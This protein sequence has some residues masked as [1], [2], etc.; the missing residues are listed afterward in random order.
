MRIMNRVWERFRKKPVRNT[1]WLLLFLKS[2]IFAIVAGDLIYYTFYNRNNLPDIEALI[3]FDVP[4]IGTIYDQN[5]KTVIHLAKE[6]RWTIKPEEIPLNVK[7]AVFSAEDKNFYSHNGVDWIA[8]IFRAGGKN[9]WHSGDTTLKNKRLTIVYQQGA[10][11][12]T[13]QLIG[14]YFPEHISELQKSWQAGII[15]RF[16]PRQLAKKTEELRLAMWTEEELAKS[17]YFGSKQ[18]VKDEILARFLSFTYFKKVYGIKAAARLYCGKEIG[19]LSYGETALL[20]GIIKQPFLYAPSNQPTKLAIQRQINR[21]NAVIDLMIENGY[22]SGGLADRLKEADIPALSDN[23]GN[24]EAPSIVGDV[25]G[26]VKKYGFDTDKIF[27][28]NLFVHTVINLDIQKIANE[29][30][31]NGLKSYEDRHPEAKG[32]IQGSVV[33]LRNSD[34]A[35][36]AEVGGRQIFNSRK[37]AYTDFN[38]VKHSLRQPGSAFKPFVYLEAIKNGWTLESVI[39]DG[40][41]AVPMGWTK[42]NDKWVKKP[43]KWISNY[44]GKFKG[45]IPLRQA[46]AESRNAATIRLA[47]IMG[48]DNVI[49]T[50]RLAGVRTKLEPYITTALG[51]S[52]VNLLELANAYRALASGVYAEPYTLAKLTDRNGEIIFVK[53]SAVRLLD[54]DQMALEQIQE[55]LRGVI[56]IPGG[57]AHSLDNEDFPIPI[58]GKTGTTNDFRDA[59]FI[60]STYGPG[61]I[62][63][64][65]RVGYDDNH[66]LGD[67]ETGA[68]VVLPIFK[69]I[70]LNVYSH[71]L[72]GPV[73]FFPESIEKNIDD[74]LHPPVVAPISSTPIR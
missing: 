52:E 39:R 20:A 25:F 18:R 15:S 14:L 38:R 46:L 48:I 70:M 65:I 49:Q 55:G 61:G 8:L 67:K 35:I 12:I 73:P 22:V 1:I 24:T 11:T 66:E 42:I 47:R 23:R 57:T 45:F 10:S 26:E 74:F 19:E 63:V 69:E 60:G 36:L 5:G 54:I 71:G 31:E 59:L 34:G 64:A 16:V 72:A 4:Q 50:A 68:R 2:V 41:I 3:R 62:T 33:V 58:M 37:I 7:Q 17:K 53:N 43:S 21:R 29:A 51:A 27:D 9:I 30:L 6:Y 44:D 40:P 56:R 32:I 28:G 13:D